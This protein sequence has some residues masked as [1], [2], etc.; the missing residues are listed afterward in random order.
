MCFQFHHFILSSLP[1]FTLVSPKMPSALHPM[2]D[3]ACCGD[4]EALRYDLSGFHFRHIALL[5]LKS[6][7]LCNDAIISE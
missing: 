5:Y 1:G 6:V 4:F 3:F 2:H 7:V